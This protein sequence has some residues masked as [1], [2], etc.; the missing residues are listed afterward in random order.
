MNLEQVF[1]KSA[2][3]F[4]QVGPNYFR[5]FGSKMVEFSEI[6]AGSVV[7][8]LACGRGAS[9]F[10]TLKT[11]CGKV[12]G[13]DFSQKMLNEVSRQ[14]EVDDSKRVELYR[15]DVGALSFQENSMDYVLCG[16]SFGF[17][18]N[19]EQVL[20]TVE[21]ILKPGGVFVVSTWKTR[22]RKGVIQSAL[23]ELFP[24]SEQ[25]ENKELV[26]V[27]KPDFGSCMGMQDFFNSGGFVEVK[28]ELHKKTFY[29]TN[30]EEW[31]E[32]QWHNATRGL[33]EKLQDSG[34]L[35]AFKQVA[36]E[37]LQAYKDENGIRFDA[38]VI[39]TR[40]RGKT[41]IPSFGVPVLPRPP[42]SHEFVES[43]GDLVQEHLFG[44][45]QVNIQ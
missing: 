18:E 44:I 29:Y 35:E 45:V 10:P 32:E 41:G 43:D 34:H 30:E 24:V 13:V 39:M 6:K 22:G 3:G 33:F 16:L 21:R 1:D 20:S 23:E 42:P 27:N 17:F 9:L 26:K 40:G 5:Y 15:M 14:I 11:G 36:I 38:E 19:P 7:L 4:D 31:W 8:D 28:T 12:V 25:K 2:K 37:Y